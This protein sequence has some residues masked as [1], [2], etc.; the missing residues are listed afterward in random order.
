M[1]VDHHFLK[2]SSLMKSTLLVKGRCVRSD[3]SVLITVSQTGEGA[4]T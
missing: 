3:I 4:V 2:L 1:T